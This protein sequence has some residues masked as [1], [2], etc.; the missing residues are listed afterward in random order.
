MDRMLQ[1]MRV[2]PPVKGLVEGMDAASDDY[3][4]N[5]APDLLNCRTTNQRWETRKGMALWDPD[6]DTGTTTF[7]GSGNV[8]GLW[9]YY[10]AAGTRFRLVARGGVLYDLEQGVDTTFQS[11]T[12]G[13]S[14]GTS[15]QNGAYNAVQVRAKLYL[16]T[17]ST[18][19][20]SYTSAASATG[21]LA[22]VAQPTAPTVAPTTKRRI[23]GVLEEWFGSAAA[24][25]AGWTETDNGNFD[26]AV[27]G[28][29]DSVPS[30]EDQAQA[31]I[32]I[33]ATGARNDS[34]YR[35]I[36]LGYT[37]NS[38]TIAFWMQQTYKRGLVR[39]E[40][41]VTGAAEFGTLLD[42][43]EGGLPYL[44]F[45]RVGNLPLLRYQRF[46]CVR[47]ADN[48][49]SLYLSRILLPGNLQGRYR[50]RFTFYNPTTGAESEPSP[51]TDWVDCS[52]IGVSYQSTDSD[53]LEKS[54]ELTTSTATLP[55]FATTTRVRWYRTGGVPALTTDPVGQPIWLRLATGGNIDSDLAGSTSAGATAATVPTGEAANLTAGDWV[56]VDRGVDG[57]QEL[58]QFEAVSNTASP[59]D[60]IRLYRDL[61]TVTDL[62]IDAGTA[63]NVTS[64]MRPFTTADAGKTV[65]ITAGT[66]FTAGYYT[67]SSVAGAIATL[68]GS[69]GTLGSTGGTA[70]IMTG[71]VY[72]HS[73]GAT[74]TPAY[75]DNVSNATIDVTT[76]LE[77]ERDDP[78][79]GIHWLSLAP[80]GRLWAARWT[81]RALGVAV[82]NKPT[83]DRPDDMDVFPDGVDPLSRRSETQGWRFDITGD[84]SGDEIVWAGFFQGV[85]TVMLRKAIYQVNA[86]SQ[87]DWSPTAVVKIIDGIGCIAGETVQE[88]DGRLY[89]VAD[90]PRVM[91]WDGRSA[92]EDLSYLRL[93]N[94]LKNAPVAYI[95]NW[96]ARAFSDENSKYYKLWITPSGGTTNTLLLDFNVLAD[97]GRGAWEPVIYN[98][99][100]DLAFASALVWN[101]PGDNRE[102]YAAALSTGIGYRLESGDTDVATAIV[103]RATSAKMPFPEGFLACLDHAWLYA[104]PAGNDTLSV[105][106]RCGAS[107]YRDTSAYAAT[108]GDPYQDWTESLTDGDTSELEFYQRLNFYALKGRWV[109]V[110]LSGSLSNRPSISSVALEWRPIRKTRLLSA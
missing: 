18:A 77:V 65:R 24:I 80:D 36:P 25:P 37:L 54:V 67:I 90:G 78:P 91:R 52:A 61:V 27:A 8:H 29:G 23:W 44:V 94:T 59:N 92:P 13:T 43:P 20:K 69:A 3:P 55:A 33:D 7:P 68:S 93:T 22:T 86:Y 51:E 102:I 75:L 100:S 88:L 101:G 76:R 97:E 70:K 105:R 19:L 46:R 47:S 64:A 56:V 32:T 45:F 31:L 26:L 66:G 17:R 14:L 30:F 85:Y 12:G 38:A 6:S 109:Q 87:A 89:W 73:S 28:T 106:V 74:V 84:G 83:I 39:Y 21:V 9:N 98:T 96:F 103:F 82:S 58:V 16:A 49:K 79:S 57:K 50:Y 110:R 42:P 48:A 34:V 81:N 71:M 2:P 5:A 60:T 107:E 35:N 41:G 4:K 63:T 104:T 1:R 40:V 15:P 72:A 53:T 62:V 99:G 11:I 10:L 108:D 95:T